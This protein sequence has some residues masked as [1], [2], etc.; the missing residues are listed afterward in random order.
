MYMEQPLGYEKKR[1]E[2]KVYKP[3]KAFYEL[4]Q[5]PRVWDSKLDQSLASLGFKG[6]SLNDPKDSLSSTKVQVKVEDATK[7]E[8]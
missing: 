6:C 8:R 5:V 7:E 3:K 4:K 1:E 2:K